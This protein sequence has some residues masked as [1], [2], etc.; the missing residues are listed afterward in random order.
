[1]NSAKLLL[2]NSGY[3]MDWSLATKQTCQCCRGFT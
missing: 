3:L 2:Q 1:M